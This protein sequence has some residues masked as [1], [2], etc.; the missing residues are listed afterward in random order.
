MAKDGPAASS[1]KKRKTLE[2]PPVDRLIMPAIAIGLAMLA[3]QF[4]KGITSE[5]SIWLRFADVTV[6]SPSF[7]RKGKAGPKLD[8]T[9]LQRTR[10]AYG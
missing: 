2:P 7:D 4:I 9:I 5:V 10:I 1:T 6:P 3:Y 8:R